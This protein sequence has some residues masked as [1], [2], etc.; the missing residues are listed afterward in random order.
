MSPGPQ[1]RMVQLYNIGMEHSCIQDAIP[2]RNGN[3][4]AGRNQVTSMGEN[5]IE[6]PDREGP[7]P[8]GI[9][10]KNELMKLF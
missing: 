5:G 8:E 3:I 10:L 4:T 6:G 2:G 9:L 1:N 7:I